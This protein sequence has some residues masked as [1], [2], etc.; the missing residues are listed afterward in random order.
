L[1]RISQSIAYNLG[2]YGG[3]IKKI[4]SFHAHAVLFLFHFIH[5]IFMFVSKIYPRMQSLNKMYVSP[6]RVGREI[7]IIKKEEKSGIKM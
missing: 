1:Q 6:A 5:F 7:K 3:I 4:L 2:R